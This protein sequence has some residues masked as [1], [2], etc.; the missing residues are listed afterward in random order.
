MSEFQFQEEEEE[1]EDDEVKQEKYIAWGI[2][3]YSLFRYPDFKF[4]PKD[5]IYR[6]HLSYRCLQISDRNHAFSFPRY[7]ICL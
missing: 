3:A 1:D 2:A 5:P 7:R 4:C 6:E